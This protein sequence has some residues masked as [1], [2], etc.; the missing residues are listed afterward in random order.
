[1]DLIGDV[2]TTAT[3]VIARERK[4]LTT[5]GR[6]INYWR[7][8]LA[9]VIYGLMTVNRIVY[10]SPVQPVHRVIEF[11]DVVMPDGLELAQTVATLRGAE[12]ISVETAVATAHPDWDTEQVAAEVQR[13]YGEMNLDVMSR[14]R[15]MLGGD[16]NE[17]LMQQ[18]EQIPHALGTTDVAQQ[19]EADAALTPYANA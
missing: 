17:S 2:A 12:A 15:V 5:H 8:A 16:P 13:I 10:R 19:V 14:A 11:P 6:K 9:D 7:P 18:F 1:M 3:E 4:S